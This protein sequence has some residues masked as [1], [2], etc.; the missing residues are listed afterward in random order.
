MSISF[1]P[2]S[3]GLEKSKVEQKDFFVI[4]NPLK[5]QKDSLQERGMMRDPFFKVFQNILFF[6]KYIKIITF[7]F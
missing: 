1:C 3:M 2:L 6:K 5:R 7:Y 4:Y